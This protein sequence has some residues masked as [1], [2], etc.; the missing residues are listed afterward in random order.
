[1]RLGLARTGGELCVVVTGASE[2]VGLQNKDAKSRERERER[3]C[4]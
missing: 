1:M 4:L 3:E 2:S